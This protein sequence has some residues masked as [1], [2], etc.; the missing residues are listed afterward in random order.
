MKVGDAIETSDF[1]GGF[2]T[3]RPVNGAIFW[4]GFAKGE[5]REGD[6]YNSL[7]IAEDG[8]PPTIVEV[9]QIVW[10]SDAADIPP[11]VYAKAKLDDINAY[12]IER[13]GELADPL[14]QWCAQVTAIM[15]TWESKGITLQAS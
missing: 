14:D 5:S 4:I 8:L 12:F 2:I 11:H 7:V 1:V 10:A 6:S 9:V 3:H 13:Y 15:K